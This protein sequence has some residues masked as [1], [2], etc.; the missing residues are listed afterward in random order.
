MLTRQEQYK[1][2]IRESERLRNGGT[3]L[4]LVV[5]VSV[6]TLVSIHN[7]NRVEWPSESAGFRK[8]PK[9]YTYFWLNFLTF[10]H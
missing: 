10:S 6:T 4:L 1:K 5:H 9:H 7:Q 3:L 8:R 2:K